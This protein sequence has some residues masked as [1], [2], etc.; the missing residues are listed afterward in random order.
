M[1]LSI[2]IPVSN[3]AKRITSTLE[4][5]LAYLK[6]QPF[7]TEIL[8]VCDGNTDNTHEVVQAFT[9]C[10]NITLKT[11]RYEQHQ[12]KG[13]AVRYGILR[14]AGDRIMFMDPDYAALIGE[15]DKGMGML[16]FGCDV[17]IGSRV[18]AGKEIISHKNVFRKLSMKIYSFIQA[19]YL[20]INYP[21]TQCGFKIFT[22]RAAFG[23]FAQQKLDSVIF[24][25][26]ILW[27]AHQA[28]YKV[29]QFPV[30]WRHLEESRIV[31]D[32]LRK[33]LFIFQEL[34]RIKKL[35]R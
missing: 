24:D 25:S 7:E 2:V 17:A 3:E 10:D 8:V 13:C 30:R 9:T 12:G 32:G 11:L 1:K 21:D 16:D 35:H 34:F 23:L 15:V 20:N 31:S 19:L 33:T 18:M 6:C 28:G 22:R 5:T 26:E 29:G 14:A 27:L 4:H